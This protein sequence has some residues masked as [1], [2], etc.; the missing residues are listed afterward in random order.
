MHATVFSGRKEVS[1]IIKSVIAVKTEQLGCVDAMDT[2]VTK[3]GRQMKQCI[4]VLIESLESLTSRP[5]EDGLVAVD[6]AVLNRHH[7][8]SSSY[9]LAIFFHV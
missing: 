1:R 3:R 8:Q 2:R 9:F 7:T 6:D 5:R 4:Q